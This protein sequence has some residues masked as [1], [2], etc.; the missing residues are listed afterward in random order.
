MKNH[1]LMILGHDISEPI[2]DPR[3]YK[4]ARSL[5]KIGVSVSILCFSTRNEKLELNGISIIRIKRL[6]NAKK[7]FKSNRLIATLA[8]LLDIPITFIRSIPRAFSIPA[9]SYHCH[10]LDTLP[11]GVFLKIAKP[12]KTLIYDT[13][14]LA[15]GLPLPGLLLF[16]MRITEM[17]SLPFVNILITANQSRLNYMQKIYSRQLRNK[18][19]YVIENFPSCSQR[20]PEQ[21]KDMK[22]KNEPVVFIYQGPLDRNR[23]I[24]NV[25]GAFVNL[26]RSDWLLYVVGGKPADVENYQNTYQNKN[27]IFTG[28][29]PSAEVFDYMNKSDIGLVALKNTCLNNYYAAPNKLY[30]Y[31]QCG[32]AVLVPDFEEI[33]RFV[34]VKQIG[35]KTSYDDPVKFQATVEK[36]LADGVS[37]IARLKQRAHSI[38]NQYEWE[39][40]ENVLQKIYL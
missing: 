37:S 5:I 11:L 35:Y 15:V 13:H 28:F 36:I 8:L 34:E 31:L 21:Q 22:H 1:T 29:I 6:F 14:E 19:S 20:P 4:E 40:N 12:S 26:K 30:E 10:D 17:F 23:G 38:S 3:V 33:G 9:N 7:I 24:D 2:L 39:Q 18:S 32:C 27:I 25:L 16:L